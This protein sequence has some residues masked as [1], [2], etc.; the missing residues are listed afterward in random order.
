MLRTEVKYTEDS[1]NYVRDGDNTRWLD[2]NGH[3]YLSPE[4]HEWA[5]GVKFEQVGA[6]RWIS[7]PNGQAIVEDVKPV[8]DVPTDEAVN[9]KTAQ[10]NKKHALRLLPLPAEVEVC[11]ALEDG[12]A[13]YGAAN[14]REKG[15]P[16]TVYIDAAMRHIKQW[17]DGGQERASDS[18]VHNLGHAMACLAILIDAQ[19]NATLHDDRPTPCR[20]TDLLLKREV[21]DGV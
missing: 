8:P 4:G 18:N 16:A 20:D 7:I 17:F 15:V 11:R 9:P 6:G 5:V 3:L 13:K 1:L 2:P 19:W 14:W 21:P 12:V 10:G